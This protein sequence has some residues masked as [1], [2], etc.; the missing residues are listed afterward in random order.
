MWYPEFLL[1]IRRYYHRDGRKGVVYYLKHRF[2]NKL[3]KPFRH[4]DLFVYLNPERVI[5][6]RFE[7]TLTVIEDGKFYKMGNYFLSN[8][9]EL[10]EDSIIY[11][12]GVLNDTAFDQAVSDTF[13]CNIFMF[14]PSIIASRHLAAIS[15]PKF[16]FREVA[17]WI[18]KTKMQFSSPLY[19]GSPSMILEHEGKTFEA[20]CEPLLTLMADNHHDIIDV[21]K[22]DIEGAAPFILNNILDNGIYPN[23]IIAEFER[24]NNKR[25][26]S[27]FEFYQVLRS[28]INRLEGLGYKIRVM[29]RDKFSYFSLELIFI[30][31]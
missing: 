15:N 29:P 25:V 2:Y 1:G 6:R 4:S 26:E 12:L 21:L 30:K 8:Q 9:Y 3:I 16:I 17:V 22:M 5:A 27:F 7:K 31:C 14:D 18:E 19:G 23:Q 13:G 11:S 10:S 24:P 20:Q 28:L